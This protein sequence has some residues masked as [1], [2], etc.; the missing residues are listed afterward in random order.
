[1][2]EL[3]NIYEGNLRYPF[4]GS[5][6]LNETYSQAYQD[7]FVLTVLN[8]KKNGWYV[9]I[10]AGVPKFCNNTYCLSKNFNWNGISI[11]LQPHTDQWKLER[12]NN[13][14]VL[15]DAFSIDY[16]NM[17]YG[18]DS[19]DYLQ[20]DIEPSQHTFE[21]LKK[22]PTSKRY[23]VITFETEYYMGGDNIIIRDESREYLKH[24]GYELIVPDAKVFW[25]GDM[26]PFEDWYVD[27]SLVNKHVALSIQE[28]AKYTQDPK[29]L[30]FN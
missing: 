18:T 30:L 24:L 21:I 23:A 29:E 9:E 4:G 22:M 16:D 12:P 1:M 3:Y 26:V 19:I 2:S 17:L 27:L 13:I 14:F 15:K 5:N 8:G 10:G 11:D 7:I 6:N 28:M 25:Q 20:L